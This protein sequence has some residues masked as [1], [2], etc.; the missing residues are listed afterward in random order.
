V[1][2]R[3]AVGGG[4]GALAELNPQD[5]ACLAEMLRKGTL[6]PVIDRQYTLAQVVD[7]ITYLE[8]G[9]ARGKGVIS[10]AVEQAPLYKGFTER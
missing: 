10:R 5:L 7:A 6:T 4:G 3:T 8:T 9:R 1:D 2:G